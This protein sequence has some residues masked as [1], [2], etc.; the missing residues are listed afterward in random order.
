VRI[1]NERSKGIGFAL[2]LT[3]GADPHDA[4]FERM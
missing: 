2:N 3:G 4:E 1:A